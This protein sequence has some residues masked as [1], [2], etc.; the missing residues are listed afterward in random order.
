MVHH[1]LIQY[2]C[3]AGQTR[4]E[5]VTEGHDCVKQGPE[6]DVVLHGYMLD[7]GVNMVHSNNLQ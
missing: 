5:S 7:N 6:C 1:A 3:V 2:L 4:S